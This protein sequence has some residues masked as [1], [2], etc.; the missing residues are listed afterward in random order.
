MSTTLEI[1]RF[2][3]RAGQEQ[4]FLAKR[5]AMLKASKEHFP[6]LIDATLAK[7]DDGTYVD[8]VLWE[9]RDACH[10]AFEQAENVAAVA[11]WLAHVDSDLEMI[12]GHV[13]DAA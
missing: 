5:T 13:V 10:A 11:E 4:E 9:T 3:V 2:S 6:G 7:L 12:F 1:G 8:I